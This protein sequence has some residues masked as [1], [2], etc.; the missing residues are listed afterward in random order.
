[1]EPPTTMW[2]P[3][4]SW[5]C[6]TFRASS[7]SWVPAPAIC[8][9]IRWSRCGACS[10]QPSSLDLPVIT[11]CEDTDIINRNMAE[12]KAKYGEDPAVE[13]HPNIRSEEACYESS[14]L[15]VELAQR[16]WYPSCISPTLRQPGSWNSSP[17]SEKAN[18]QGE[19]QGERAFRNGIPLR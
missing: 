10:R 3:L 5:M 1:M 18:R 4:P 2:I 6:I 13:H 12:A 16:V 9:W 17:I 14:K 8:W 11:H 7:S 15:A 19:L